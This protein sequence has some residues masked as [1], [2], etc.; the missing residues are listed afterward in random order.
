MRDDPCLSDVDL[1]LLAVLNV[2]LE[3]RSVRADPKSHDAC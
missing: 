2:L 3:E 1:N